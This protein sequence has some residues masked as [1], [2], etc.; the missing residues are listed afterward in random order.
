MCK[1]YIFAKNKNDTKKKRLKKLYVFVAN[2]HRMNWCSLQYL[3]FIIFNLTF[4]V[5]ACF[6]EITWLSLLI[7]EKVT[8]P[9]TKTNVTFQGQGFT[10]TAIAWNDT[11]NSS[12]GASFSGSVQVYSTNFVAKNITFMVRSII[13]IYIY[14]HTQRVDHDSFHF[15]IQKSRLPFI[16]FVKKM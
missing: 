16:F 1:I 5:L 7:S 8:V 6:Y 3:E 14:T 15:S 13:Y 2:S 9:R 4:I 11:A 12:H 10:S